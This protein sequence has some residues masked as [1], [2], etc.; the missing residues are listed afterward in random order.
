MKRYRVTIADINEGDGR[1]EFA[2]TVNAEDSYAAMQEAVRQTGGNGTTFFP[3]AGI[4]RP[5]EGVWYGQLVHLVQRE[6]VISAFT[7]RMRV[8]VTEQEG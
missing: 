5:A 1:Y 8:D 3:D 6:G 7:G 2:G 4:S